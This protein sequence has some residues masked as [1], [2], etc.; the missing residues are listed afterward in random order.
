MKV[1]T[2]EEIAVFVSK[3]YLPFKMNS[4]SEKLNQLNRI[5]RN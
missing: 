5:L 1:Q 3:K 4:E 2:F